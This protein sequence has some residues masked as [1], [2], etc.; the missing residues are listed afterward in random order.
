MDFHKKEFDPSH[1]QIIT[2]AGRDI[3]TIEVLANSERKLI[4]KLY[5]LSEFQG[6]GIGSKILRDVIDSAQQEGLRLRLGVLKI[7]PAVRFYERHGFQKVEETDTQW[8]ME[9]IS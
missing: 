8:K 9:W 1:L 3:G 6:R 2:H 4:N 5:I 7:N